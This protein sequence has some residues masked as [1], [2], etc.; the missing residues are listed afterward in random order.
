VPDVG[1][2]VAVYVMVLPNTPDG[3]VPPVKGAVIVVAVEVIVPNTIAVGPAR[4]AG[5]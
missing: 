1:V 3:P 2:A 5:V 4:V